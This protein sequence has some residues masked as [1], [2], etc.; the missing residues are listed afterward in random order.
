[1]REKPRWK[2]R[3][4][5]LVSGNGT[6]MTPKTVQ[7]VL[8]QVED[9]QRLTYRL[10]GSVRTERLT[11]SVAEAKMVIGYIRELLNDIEVAVE[12]E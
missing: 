4:K 2:T 9:V 5:L 3:L 7:K 6:D 1:M 10:D 12:S 8:K 11:G